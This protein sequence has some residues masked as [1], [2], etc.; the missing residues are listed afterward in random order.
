MKKMIYLIVLIATFSI[1]CVCCNETELSKLSSVESSEVVLSEGIATLKTAKL[2]KTQAQN[3]LIKFI[4]NISKKTRGNNKQIQI[5]QCDSILIPTSGKT[6]SFVNDDTTIV[7]HFT[8]MS[9]E[10]KGYALVGNELL[11]PKLI[12]YCPK[13]TLQDTID[14]KGLANYI[15]R[16]FDGFRNKEERYAKLYERIEKT[17]MTRSAGLPNLPPDLDSVVVKDSVGKDT[18]YKTLAIY[19]NYYKEIAEFFVPVEWGQGY[20]YNKDVPYNCG[21]GKA[22]AGCTAIAVAQ[23][24]AYHKYPISYNWDLLTQTPII[25]GTLEADEVRRNEVA[26]LIADIGGKV[27]MDYGCS[28]STSNIYEAKNA[29]GQYGY[30]VSSV[31]NFDVS[32]ELSD[33]MQAL[34]GTTTWNPTYH[35]NSPIY[36]RGENS[37]GGHAFVGDG[38]AIDEECYY[39]FYLKY[40]KGELVDSSLLFYMPAMLLGNTCYIHINWGW[41]GSSNGWYQLSLFNQSEYNSYN[42][43]MFALYQIVSQ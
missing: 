20:P 22:P 31:E 6:R 18:L 43:Q 16:A 36:I 2:G 10:G 42:E 41:N 11:S 4:G 30:R 28:G 37:S 9:S 5:I 29:F 15:Q 21:N 1:C 8:I 32:V 23:I 40:L 14:N 39:I 3:F 38:R 12:A 7:Y 34:L 35:F 19:Q 25:S 26:K 13:G 24:M 33:I 27:H 17:N